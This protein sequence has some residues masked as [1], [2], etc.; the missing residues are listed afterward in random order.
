[1]LGEHLAS[2]FLLF[3][4]SLF[5]GQVTRESSQTS[6]TSAEF[7]LLLDLGAQKIENL[8]LEVKI[9]PKMSNFRPVYLILYHRHF[10]REPNQLCINSSECSNEV[11]K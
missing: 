3:I 2:V 6:P 7:H 11:L 9:K 10:L 1:M 8:F 4:V 5:K